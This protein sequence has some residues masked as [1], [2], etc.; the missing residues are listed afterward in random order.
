MSPA[1]ALPSVP[2]A[3]PSCAVGICSIAQFAPRE[4]MSSVLAGRHPAGPGSPAFW[5][6]DFPRPPDGTRTCSAWGFAVPHSADV[7]RF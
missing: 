6:I 3:G 7:E 2:W 5:G 4:S 1:T